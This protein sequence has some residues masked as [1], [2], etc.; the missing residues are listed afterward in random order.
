MTSESMF[1]LHCLLSQATTTE[2]LY[3]QEDFMWKH[4]N[5]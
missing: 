5:E 4:N 3:Y 1:I 2:T